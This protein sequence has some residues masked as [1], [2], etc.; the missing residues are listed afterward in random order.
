MTLI[1]HMRKG[2]TW[3]WARAR[4]YSEAVAI[5]RN[6]GADDFWIEGRK[7]RR[8]KIEVGVDDK[9]AEE[10]LRDFGLL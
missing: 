1:V 7:K 5:A 3:Y 8:K 2:K 9:T 6:F 10:V 4:S